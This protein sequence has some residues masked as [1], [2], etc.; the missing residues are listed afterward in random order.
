MSAQKFYV[1]NKFW[2]ELISF[3]IKYYV[4]TGCNNKVHTSDISTIFQNPI[5]WSAMS[6]HNTCVYFII[7]SGGD[8]ALFFM[9]YNNDRIRAFFI[10]ICEFEFSKLQNTSYLIDGK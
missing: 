1:Q 5:H 6:G 3:L 7:V 10:Q 8:I 9:C 4:S 2:T